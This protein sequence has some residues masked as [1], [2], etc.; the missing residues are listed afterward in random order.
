MAVATPGGGGG[1][2]RVA[3]GGSTF[4]CSCRDV[5]EEDAFANTQVAD[6]TFLNGQGLGKTDVTKT[7]PP[8]LTGTRHS[9]PHRH[10]CWH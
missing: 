3:R 6:V 9:G 7:K 1:T 5:Y 2:G 8:A 10:E 4:I